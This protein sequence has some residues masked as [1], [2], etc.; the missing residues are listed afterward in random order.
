MEQNVKSARNG[1]A[2]AVVRVGDPVCEPVFLDEY[3][4]N[5]RP[6]SG[7]KLD[8]EPLHNTVKVTILKNER[9]TIHHLG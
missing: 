1:V 5:S 3:G 9:I 6:R 8:R 4:M 2:V 7:M